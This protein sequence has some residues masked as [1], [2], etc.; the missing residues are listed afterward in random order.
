MN[1]YANYWAHN[2]HV[3]Y[4]EEWGCN[5]NI[6]YAAHETRTILKVVFNK[7]QQLSAPQTV[8]DNFGMGHGWR[9]SKSRNL[10]STFTWS[11]LS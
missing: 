5:E 9:N 6:F 10:T 7:I 3:N 11:Y 2:L 1:I 4:W 8:T